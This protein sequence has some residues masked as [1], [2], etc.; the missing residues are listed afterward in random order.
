MYRVMDVCEVGC[1]YIIAGCGRAGASWVQIVILF[2]VYA[3][4]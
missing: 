4:G 2:V 3:D 1:V